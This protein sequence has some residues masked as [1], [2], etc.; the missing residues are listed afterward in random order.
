MSIN[1]DRFKMNADECCAVIQISKTSFYQMNLQP[2]DGSQKIKLYDIREVVQTRLEKLKSSNQ[3]D[4][5]TNNRARMELARAIKIEME[6]AETMG[7]T[8]KVSIVSQIWSE[9]LA[10]FKARFLGQADILPIRLLRA[11]TEQEMKQIIL[12]ANIDALNELQKYDMAE[13]FKNGKA[14]IE[15][16]NQEEEDFEGQEPAPKKSTVRSNRG[17]KARA[18]K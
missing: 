11:N 12:D 10:T 4:G 17:K 14:L 1:Q 16:E 3:S 6:N 7:I 18:A 5:L 8:V 15:A 9:L 2:V 13:I